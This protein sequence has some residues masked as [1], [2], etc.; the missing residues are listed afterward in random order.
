MTQQHSYLIFRINNSLYGVSTLSVK[1]IFLLPELT[2]ILEAPPGIVGVIDVRGQILPV[3]DLNLRFGQQT[4]N[5]SLTTQVIVIE[6]GEQNLGI[7]VEEVSQVRDLS[8]RDTPNQPVADHHSH[9]FIAGVV[10][11]ENDILVIINLANLIK[12]VF[13][14]NYG[15]RQNYLEQPFPVRLLPSDYPQQATPSQQLIIGGEQIKSSS[16]ANSS[17]Q[18][19][20]EALEILR[21]RA[22]R[23]RQI[24]EVRQNADNVKNL[25]IIVL[26]QELFSVDLENVRE[27][28]NL[29]QVVPVPC[30]PPHIIGNMNLRGEI[31]TLIDICQILNLPPINLGTISQLIVVEVD[32]LRVGLAIEKVRDTISVNVGEIDLVPAASYSTNKKYFQGTLSYQKNTI[33]ILNISSILQSENLVVDQSG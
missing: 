15:A 10:R 26:N 5:Y 20:S 30:C 32:D 16:L 24:D 28:T 9:P 3:M 31:L 29:E 6:Q 7:I 18:L 11:S 27:F 17:T 2:P 4:N 19:T 23:L 25:A 33:S 21:E 12:S 1:E 14:P 22:N 8:V 13:K